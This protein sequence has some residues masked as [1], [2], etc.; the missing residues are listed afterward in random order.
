VTEDSGAEAQKRLKAVEATSDGFVLAQ[1]DLELRGP[2]EFL[3]IR[4]SGFPELRMASVSDVGLIE[5]ARE[6]AIRF[7][8]TD[9]GLSHPDHHLLARR[10]AQSWRGEGDVS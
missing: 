4:Q 5:K 3:G 10:V 7:F 2:G 9:P 6:S 1:K 8:E